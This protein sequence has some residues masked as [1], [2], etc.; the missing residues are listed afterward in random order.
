MLGRTVSSECAD[1]G[2]VELEWD[3]KN[4]GNKYE[5]SANFETATKEDGSNFVVPAGLLSVAKNSLVDREH[6]LSKDAILSSMSRTVLTI[7]GLYR[8]YREISPETVLTYS[9]VRRVGKARSTSLPHILT[10]S[11]FPISAPGLAHFDRIDDGNDIVIANR[12]DP[13]RIYRGPVRK[14]SRS[15]LL[16]TVSKCF[17]PTCELIKDNR[18]ILM[19]GNTL[20][21]PSPQLYLPNKP[22]VFFGCSIGQKNDD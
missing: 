20:H 11:M 22:N 3:P 7:D 17:V 13:T 21:Q 18:A 15:F 10:A 19:D 12:G 2:P 14:F 1:I 5:A 6:L 8:D 4:L 16:G 9:A